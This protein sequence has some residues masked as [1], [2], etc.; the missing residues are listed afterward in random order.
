MEGRGPCTAQ[1][2]LVPPASKYADPAAE[3]RTAPRRKIERSSSQ[4]LRPSLRREEIG[5]VGAGL[6][7]QRGPYLMLASRISR[8]DKKTREFRGWKKTKAESMDQFSG[9][10]DGTR[11]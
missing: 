9:E 2:T 3:D 1:K 6:T 4:D 7:R 11:T 8:V 5:S 10:V